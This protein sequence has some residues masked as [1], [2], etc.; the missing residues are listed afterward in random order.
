MHEVIKI[1][2]GQPVQVAI[3]LIIPGVLK[4]LRLWHID[5]LSQKPNNKD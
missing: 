4:Q 5:Y 3:V 2:L 1:L